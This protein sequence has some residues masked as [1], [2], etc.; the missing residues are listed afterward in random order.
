MQDSNVVEIPSVQNF[1]RRLREDG[2]V[3]WL[4]DD[5]L[6]IFDPQTA[7]QVE[8]ANYADLTM[9]DGFSDVIRGR[10]SEPMSWHQVRAAWLTQMRGLA[11]AEGLRG[12]AGRMQRLLDAELGREQ[13]LVWLAERA[14]VEPLVATIID[15]LSPRA[16]RRVVR[17]VMSK[18]ALVLSDVD[19]H[20]CPPLHKTRMWAYQFI[21]GLE[22][23]RELK[24]RAHGTRPR[25]QDL[26]DPMVDLLP[27]LGL[28]RAADAVTALLTALTASP[29]A[30]AACLFYEWHRQ[31]AWRE[32]MVEELTQ[33]PEQA[34]YASPVRAAPATARFA[35]EVLRIWSS[36]P[37]VTR[38]VRT[39]I[40]QG[41]TELKTGQVYV[42][43]S[44]FIHHDAGKWSDP[45]AFDPD[46]WLAE[47]RERCPHGSYVPF[48]WAPKSCIGAN[49]GL[50]Q[51][52]LM[53]HL[54]ATRYHLRVSDPE[55]VK[56]VIAS[57]VRPTDFAGTVARR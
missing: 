42:L 9:L 48:G 23:R 2:E 11:D 17:E 44:F 3:F 38:R 33:V 14:M 50:S 46:R 13:D 19:R 22:V 45:E 36:P 43:S 8:S 12:L 51:L 24:G 57:V 56:M 28:D 27:G 18:V 5:A 1:R 35:K 52:I 40:C 34:L 54:L 26:T 4:Q 49:L 55:R 37:I 29:G 25:R 30:A 15:G 10:A 6:A 39:D 31:P 41:Q 32:R 20:R 16:H 53:A 47:S 21:V 7:Q